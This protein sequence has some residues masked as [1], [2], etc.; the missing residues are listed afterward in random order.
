MHK[1]VTHEIATAELGQPEPELSPL[2]HPLHIIL[3]KFTYINTS[4]S[5]VQYKETRVL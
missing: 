3:V 5:K 1:F 4:V 2:V